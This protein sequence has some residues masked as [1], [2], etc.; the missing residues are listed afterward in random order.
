MSW[1]N[2]HRMDLHRKEFWYKGGGR[3][4]SCAG[5]TKLLPQAAEEAGPT[6]LAQ[7]IAVDTYARS[8]C[9]SI[10]QSALNC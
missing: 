7:N 4:A 10:L 9:K 6:R 1:T 3:V 2:L 5:H 8:K